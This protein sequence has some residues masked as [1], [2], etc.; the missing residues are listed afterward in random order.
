MLPCSR[1]PA[2]PLLTLLHF[3]AALSARD[4]PLETVPSA[5]DLGDGPLPLLAAGATFLPLTSF[6]PPSTPLCLRAACPGGGRHFL[7]LTSIF[8]PLRHVR[9]LRILTGA[10]GRL[11]VSTWTTS[12]HLTLLILLLLCVEAPSILVPRPKSLS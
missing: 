8:W 10:P 12:G 2:V 11:R 5:L 4:H 1:L 9:P 7:P 3:L 6:S